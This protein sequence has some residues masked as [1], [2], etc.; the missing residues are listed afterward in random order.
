MFN[1]NLLHSNCGLKLSLN[2]FLVKSKILSQRMMTKME[3]L[4]GIVER[5]VKLSKFEID[6]MNG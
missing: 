1:S 4:M 3:S 5:Y 6:H 2:T